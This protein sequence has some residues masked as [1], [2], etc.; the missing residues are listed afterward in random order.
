MIQ[1]LVVIFTLFAI[2][3]FRI[4]LLNWVYKYDIIFLFDA[5]ISWLFAERSV[6]II[7][8]TLSKKPD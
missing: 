7:W 3:M 8:R 2:I 5:R 4:A 6:T 1:L